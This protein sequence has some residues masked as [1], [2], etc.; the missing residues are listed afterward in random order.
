MDLIIVRHAKSLHEE[1]IS[2]DIERHLFERGYSDAS[3][4]ADWCIVKKLK[5]D[6]ILSSPAIRAYST[7]LIFANKFGYSPEQIQL[8]NAI[9]E[10][11]YRSLLMVLE[12]SMIVDG[13]YMLFGH[14]PGLTD[15]INFLC[16]PVCVNLPTSALVHIRLNKDVNKRWREGAGDVIQKF[17]GHKSF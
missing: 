10:A 8:K 13:T 11:T 4:S 3:L 5:P 7:A 12:E 1:Y 14:N 9:Y 6:F 16:G 17:S 15:L 2:R